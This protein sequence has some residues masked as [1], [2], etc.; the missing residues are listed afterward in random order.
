MK[1]PS[2]FQ[3]FWRTRAVL[4]FVFLTLSACATVPQQAQH[5]AL[6]ELTISELQQSLKAGKQTCVGVVDAYLQRIEHFDQSSKLNAIILINPRAK[7]KAQSLD[8]QRE[9]GAPMRALHCVPVILKDNF[10]TADMPTEAGSMVL[11]GVIPPDDAFMVRRL[12]EEEAIMLAKSNMAEWAFSPYHSISSTHGET[13][14]PYDLNRV[15]AGSSGGTAA[16]VA[17]NFGLV[18]M[19][20]DTGNSIRGPSSH[21]AL[22]GMRST[23]GATSRDGI[24]PLVLNRDIGGPMTRTVEDNARVFSV[25]A[26]VDPTDPVTR[27][28]EK[29]LPKDFHSQLSH[30]ALQGKRIG[31]LRALSDTPT[32]DPDIETLFEQAIKDL[33]RLGAEI[34]DP[35]DIDGLKALTEATGFC[36][37]FRYDI[38]HYFQSLGDRSP[39]KNLGEVAASGKFLPGN[40]GAMKWAMS[41][42]VAPEKQNPPCVDVEGDPRRKRLLDAVI[43]AMDKSGIDALVYPS[44]NN[45]P[46]EIGDLDS[47]HG[48]N[49]PI[50]APHSGQPAIT[51][52]MGFTSEGLPAGLQILGRPYSEALLYQ[53][54]YAYER[55]TLHRREPKNFP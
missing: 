13:R 30:E 46:R 51:V 16:A 40:D 54:A 43:N 21:T 20:S 10:D 11:K 47:P 45:P 2:H 35:L 44:W 3:I 18:G 37:R 24:V 31:V 5:F 28:A 17:A 36:S 33:K 15:P 55:G 42:D 53:L 6:G 34:V 7:E 49:S 32:T 8:R 41:V 19:G 25:V 50:I 23:I 12:R 26:G 38:D 9:S 29:K 22:V 48:N 52:P 4:F 39:V 27:D 14:N 1:K